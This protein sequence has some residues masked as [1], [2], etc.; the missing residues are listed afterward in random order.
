MLPVPIEEPVARLAAESA[1][2]SQSIEGFGCARSYSSIPKL[3]T[4]DVLS[5][6]KTFVLGQAI[7][8]RP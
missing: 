2:V 1:V 3:A 4:D 5:A 8:V 7:D 6:S